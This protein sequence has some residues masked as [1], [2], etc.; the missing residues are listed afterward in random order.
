MRL[1]AVDT[2]TPLSSV[3]AFENERLAGE[4]VLSE[5]RAQSEHLLESVRFLFGR[6][7]WQLSEIDLFVGTSGPGS[8]TGLRVGIGSVQG[9]ALSAERPV[10]G[11]STLAAMAM[12]AIVSG[13]AAGA[14]S[15][16]LLCPVIDAGRGELYAGLFRAGSHPE[17]VADEVVLAP[18]ELGKYIDGRRSFIFG[19]G[20]VDPGMMT[21]HPWRGG[22]AAASGRLVLACLTAG[23]QPG[24][25]PLA[26]RYVRRSDARLPSG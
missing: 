26:A 13:V 2:A 11:V 15:E 6:I 21:F 16:S 23:R 22:L 5:S 19:W 14:A 18:A 24:D 4:I 3:A 7:H 25:M 17:P 10:A 12:Q 20:G 9:M 8:F 1:L